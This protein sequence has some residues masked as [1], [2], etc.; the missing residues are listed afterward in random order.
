MVSG[1]RFSDRLAKALH[2]YEPQLLPAG[3]T[4]PAAVAVVLATDGEGERLLVIERARREG[5]PWS[6]HLAFPGGRVD[7]E[8]PSREHAARREVLEEVGVD[9]ERQDAD[10]LG[11]LSD[12]GGAGRP[13]VVSAFVYRLPGAVPLTPEPGEVADA[14]WVPVEHLIDPQRQ[15]DYD[16]HWNGRTMK[17]PAIDLLGPGKPRLWGLTYRFTAHMLDLLGHTLPTWRPMGA[18]R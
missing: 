18:R 3:Q 8:D 15:T 5:D 6:G 4:R 13:V 17:A 16:F 9:L 14:F 2:R 10:Y 12:I 7:P 1:S 11:R